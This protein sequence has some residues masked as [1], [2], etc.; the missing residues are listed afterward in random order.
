[1]THVA[2]LQA[3]INTQTRG[4]LNYIGITIRGGGIILALPCLAYEVAD[5]LNLLIHIF[6]VLIR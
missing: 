1:M 2:G 5:F 3:A 6:I 4:V